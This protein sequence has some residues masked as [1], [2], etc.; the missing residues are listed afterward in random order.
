[1]RADR[2]LSLLLLLQARGRMTARQLADE[3]EVSERT[4]YR[5]IDA[6]SISGVPVYGD[7]GPDGGYAL[8]E[9]YRTTLT[10]L[11]APEV[12]ALF[13]LSIPSPLDE[14]GVS[15]E[16]RSAM[17]KLVAALPA[18]SREDEAWVRERIYLDATWWGQD[19]PVPHL[20]VLH[21]AIW[22]DELVRIT[23]RHPFIAP[24]GMEQT[25]APYG[26]VAKGGVW[27]LVCEGNGRIRAHRVSTLVDA[28]LTGERFAR[29]PGFD[30][31]A[32]WE[33][34]C[35]AE[36]PPPSYRV[37]VRVSPGLAFALPW[38]LGDRTRAALA[39]APRDAE[40]WSVLELSFES[41]E[42]ARARLL[43]FGGG[44]V[45]LEPE[46]LR[47]SVL[48]FARQTIARYQ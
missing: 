4:I 1:M 5:D 35:T 40:G 7:R 47:L 29:P 42:D 36:S 15:G 6:L 30:L 14:L 44:A 12:R 34:W 45:V 23:Y 17:L 46:E 43:S 32:F 26:L 39:E 22:Q 16:L 9:S 24:V 38:Y 11:S 20:Q 48:D 37:R 13:M 19:E 3:L 8:V 21:R 41:F 28:S 18:T 31:R 33:A 25:V 2:L 10:G 27:Y